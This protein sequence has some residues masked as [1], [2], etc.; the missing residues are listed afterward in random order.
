MGWPVSPCGRGATPIGTPRGANKIGL[1][2]GS[3]FLRERACCVISSFNM[4]RLYQDGSDNSMR[5]P[6]ARIPLL[7]CTLLFCF[8]SENEEGARAKGTAHGTVIVIFFSEARVILA[9]DS[10]VT[11]SGAAASHE[12]RQCKVA[13]LG[14]DT[15]FSASG[16]T[17][18]KFD[19]PKMP[20][21]DVYQEARRAALAVPSDAPDR[22]RSSAEIWA[23]RVKE[24]LDI[25][26]RLHPKAVMSLMHGRSTQL[27]GAIFAGHSKNGLSVY[28]VAI[29]CECGL[30]NKHASIQTSELHPVSDG[31][32]AAS[33]GTAET[34]DLFAEVAEMNT[35]RGIAER[36]A[37][38]AAE[39]KPDR[40][41][42]V[43]VRTGEFI[44]RNSKDSTI[45]GPINAIELAAQGGVRWVKREKNCQ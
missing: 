24:A 22:A 44:L 12:D 29:R 18:Y 31:V 15:I 26:L 39:G 11:Y 27:A 1:S 34:M 41:V 17:R 25:G 32:P 8:A 10:R 37:W 38:L 36:D 33:I 42:Y 28:Y 13:D 43:T 2:S 3:G 6:L 5:K 30:E 4:V 40:D 7:L 16:F 21:F 14:H 45:A 20:K 35:P 19:D 9:A 23:R